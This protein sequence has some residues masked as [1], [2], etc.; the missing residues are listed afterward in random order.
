MYDI[1]KIEVFADQRN[2]NCILISNDVKQKIFNMKEDIN[3][4][5][6]RFNVS[7]M[8]LIKNIFKLKF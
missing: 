3:E 8:K 2:S 1:N 7:R 6:D 4:Y 5:H